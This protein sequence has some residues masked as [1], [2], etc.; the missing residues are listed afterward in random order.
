MGSWYVVDNFGN[1]VMGP[2]V[3]KQSAQIICP[4]GYTVVFVPY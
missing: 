1:Q 4:P 2:F 3:D